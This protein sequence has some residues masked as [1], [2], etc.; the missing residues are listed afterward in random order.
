MLLRFIPR[1]LVVG[2]TLT[3]VF[4]SAIHFRAA[5]AE[6]TN[7]TETNSQ[8]DVL[9][10]ECSGFNITTS[11][12][13]EIAHQLIADNTGDEV[14]EQL[15]VDFTGSLGNAESG[16][17]YRYDGHFTRWSDYIQNRVM[18]TD[19]ELRFELGTPGQFKVAI[20][21]AEM[22]LLPDTAEII[23]QFVPN[24]LQMELCYMLAGAA[25]PLPYD[26]SGIRNPEFDQPSPKVLTHSEW[27][28]TIAQHGKPC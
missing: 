23:K 1:L 8:E 21:R 14:S 17:S 5:A 7:W 18:V 27:C 26:E 9:V 4:A 3:L 11:Y 22:D 25:A 19:F 6:R 20:D 2:L 10:Q 12:S 28:D 13:A 24:A 15:N 16:E